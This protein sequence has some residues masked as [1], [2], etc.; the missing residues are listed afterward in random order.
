MA[1]EQEGL[2]EQ[3]TPAE[4]EPQATETPETHEETVDWQK[5]YKD[6]QTDHTQT[7]QRLARLEEQPPEEPPEDDYEDEGFVDRKTVKKIVTEAVTKAVSSVRMQAADSYFRRTYKDLVKH[8]NAISGILRNP[9]DPTSLKGASAEE[10]IDAA[11]KEFNALTE[12]AKTTAKAEAEAA[13]KEREEKNRLAAGLGGS[14]TPPSKDETVVTDA[15]EIAARKAQSAKR[16]NM[17]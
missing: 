12:E 1:E 16:R 2:Q 13:A 3:E 4:S 8:E 17:A 10:R 9:K 15:Q 14:P 11:V 5:R 7:K 6:L